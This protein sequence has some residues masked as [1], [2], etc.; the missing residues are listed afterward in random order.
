[1]CTL[2]ENTTDTEHS[3]AEESC[4]MVKVPGSSYPLRSRN[5]ENLA[6]SGGKSARVVRSVKQK[7]VELQELTI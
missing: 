6:T 4:E 1:M 5:V 3:Q 7:I 2:K